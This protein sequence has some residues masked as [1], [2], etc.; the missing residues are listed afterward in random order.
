M[1]TLLFFRSRTETTPQKTRDWEESVLDFLQRRFPGTVYVLPHI[2]DLIDGPEIEFLRSLKE[3]AIVFS[4]ISDRAAFWLLKKW[5]IQTEIQC[6]DLTSLRSE[7]ENSQSMESRSME[8][9]LELGFFAQENLQENLNVQKRQ[10]VNEARSEN[11]LLRRW[12]P[13]IDYQACVGCLEC[14]NYCLF[15]VYTIG[16][17]DKPNVEL[18]DQ[19]RDG[20]P[21][22]SRVCPGGAIMFAEYDDPIISGRSPHE[23][24]ANDSIK[25]VPWDDELDQLI[26]NVG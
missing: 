22:C 12:Y 18:P 13:I 9:L 1:N 4:W 15:G 7:E 8:P 19:C 10:I 26:D 2:Y 21:A 16:E 24:S 25:D 5:N 6:F 14:V 17:Q 11:P 3:S 20:C 23:K